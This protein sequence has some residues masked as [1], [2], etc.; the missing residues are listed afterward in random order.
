MLQVIVAVLHLIVMYLLYLFFFGLIH[1]FILFIWV[2]TLKSICCIPSISIN[3]MSIFIV[4]IW[5]MIWVWMS[6]VRL[7]LWWSRLI[8]F[9]TVWINIFPFLFTNVAFLS[10]FYF[11]TSFVFVVLNLVFKNALSNIIPLCSSY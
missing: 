11:L 4:S 3:I 8:L 7:S 2:Y 1:P 5:S 9:K 6:W 10:S